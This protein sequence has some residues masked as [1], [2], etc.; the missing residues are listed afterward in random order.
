MLSI[1]GLSATLCNITL[2]HYAECHHIASAYCYAECPCAE[3]HNNEC[4]YAECRGANLRIECLVKLYFQ[5]LD[6]P[7]CENVAA[8]LS[9]QSVKKKTSFTNNDVSSKYFSFMNE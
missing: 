6:L 1:V 7:E 8:Y 2:S 9:Q 4:F 3:C 5:T